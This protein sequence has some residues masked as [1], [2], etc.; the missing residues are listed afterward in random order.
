[1]VS[2][3]WREGAFASF[4]LAGLVTAELSLA[5][6]GTPAASE[7]GA[8]TVR[9]FVVA[10]ATLRTVELNL[11]KAVSG[12]IRG[13]E[14]H[15]YAV[16]LKPGQ[17]AAIRLDQIDDDL[18]FALFDPEDRL[19]DIADRNGRGETEVA[20][21]VAAQSGNYT[22]QVANFDSRKPDARYAIAL[23]RREPAA[24]GRA[25][26]AD[27]LLSS[28]YAPDRPGAAIEVQRA[29]KVVYR[30]AVGLA[31]VEHRVPITRATRFEL[32]SVSKQFTAFG[33][34]LLI[35]RGLLDEETEV[36]TILPELPDFGHRITI[37]HLLNH[38][39]GIRDWDAP[40]ALL[41]VRIEDGITAAQVLRWVAR[42][43][44]LNFPP[45]EAQQYSN[46]G[47][48]LLGIVIERLTS[49]PLDVWMQANVFA[50]IGMHDTTMSLDPRRVIANNAA[51]YKQHVPAPMLV[52][53]RPGASGGSSSVI[54]TLD[55]LGRWARH[56]QTGSVGGARVL[57][58]ITRP[59]R[60][61][62]GKP[63]TYVYGN[64]LESREGVPVASHLGLAAGFRTHLSRFPQSGVSVI[65]LA[66]D[67][68]DATYARAK[69]I[70]SLFVDIP[71][72]RFEPPPTDAAPDP[73]FPFT[74]DPG[75]EGVYV[76]DEIETRYHLRIQNGALIA[77]HAINGE[78][79][80]R[81]TQPD[82]FT[83]DQWYLPQLKFMR[84]ERHVVNA[85]SVSTD[86]A[87]DMVFR[88][89][90]RTGATK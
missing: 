1:M 88:K 40:F 81:Q 31:N 20:T 25:A 53:A 52:S 77:T 57:G 74:A 37:G 64:W 69:Q 56:Y 38:T 33:I 35:E 75:Y 84:D 85:F 89:G 8:A 36:R 80:L 79:R 11:G 76:S 17:F 86:G 23:A 50:P 42:Q 22:V 72:A 67:G 70:E 60:L 54:S 10:D 47:Y 5:H 24:Q 27:Q 46:T 12:R 87:R 30:R 15:R 55:D 51:S 44:K 3:Q 28:W 2:I 68:D 58:R 61:A 34:A 7:M 19:I 65:Y 73:A 4:A 71:P 41:G 39:S 14:V 43:E 63:N 62:D 82:A 21:L 13:A 90:V 32:A 9:R 18:T 16:S 83:S 49:T 26:H 48:T 66:N 6:A 78:I 59:G 29:G 45:G